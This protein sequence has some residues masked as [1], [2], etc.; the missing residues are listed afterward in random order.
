M[1]GVWWPVAGN[2]RAGHRPPTT[3][4]MN[5]IVCLKQILDPEIPMRDFKVDPVSKEAVR[6]ASNLVTNIFCENALETALQFK[7]KNGAGKITALCFA[8]ESG[9]DTLRKALAMKADEGVQVINDVAA[10]PDPL[11]VARTLAAA[12]RKLG[13]FDVVMVGRESGDWG[14]GQTGGLLAE[15]LGVPYVGF[16]DHIEANGSGVK[17]GVL[18][19]GVASLSISQ[20]KGSLGDVTVL[21]GQT[22]DGDEG[23]AMLEIIHAIAPSAKL[24]FATAFSTTTM[25]AAAATIT[26][27]AMAT[28]ATVGPRLARRRGRRVATGVGDRTASSVGLLPTTS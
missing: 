11:M 17:V 12:I 13:T 21:S 26:A 22:G 2:F 15:E 18:S 25:H 4:L 27:A 8:P 24:Y 10:H 9:E 3:S 5:I 1:V 23:T 16:V 14:V 28:S 7:E 6:G 19:D 20:A